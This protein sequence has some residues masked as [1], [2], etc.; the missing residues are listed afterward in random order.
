MRLQG[1]MG[2]R[3][4]LSERLPLIIQPIYP[5]AKR[6]D[7]LTANPEHWNTAPGGDKIEVSKRTD[8]TEKWKV[9][10]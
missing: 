3:G 9:H 4:K 6:D 7:E 5:S 10:V 2:I 1:M 8:R